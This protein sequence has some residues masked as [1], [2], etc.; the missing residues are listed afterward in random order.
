M[1]SGHP[2]PISQGPST[3]K[4][5]FTN[6]SQP[7]SSH[8]KK[9]SRVVKFSHNYPQAAPYSPQIVQHQIP[10]TVSSPQY[11]QHPPPQQVVSYM[12]PK[13]IQTPSINQQKLVQSKF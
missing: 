10:Y 2:Y 5:V 12:S 3:P 8:L 13:I 9:A 7:S 6:P 11:S 1:I 4:V